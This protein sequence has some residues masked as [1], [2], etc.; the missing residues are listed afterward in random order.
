MVENCM[1]VLLSVVLVKYQFQIIGVFVEVSV[2]AT[3]SGSVPEVTFVVKDATGMGSDTFTNNVCI[4][5]LLPPKYATV[6][7]TDQLPTGNI[8]TAC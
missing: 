1:A 4:D 5:T 6:R 2:N 8:P 7:F 3:V